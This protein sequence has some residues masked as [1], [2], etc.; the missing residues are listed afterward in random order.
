MT[1][2]ILLTAICD[3]KIGDDAC[4]KNYNDD[5]ILKR[6]GTVERNSGGNCSSPGNCT[7]CHDGFY[8]NG[9]YCESM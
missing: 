2:K 5:Q 3:G 4:T 6:D 8:A 9:S 1:K 7:N